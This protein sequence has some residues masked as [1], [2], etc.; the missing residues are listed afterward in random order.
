MH[1]M[2]EKQEKIALSDQRVHVTNQII[3]DES[4]RIGKG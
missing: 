4:Y 1:K 2:E 3:K